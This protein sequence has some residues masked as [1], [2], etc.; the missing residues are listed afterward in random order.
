[1][2]WALVLQHSAFLVQHASFKDSFPDAKNKVRH[3]KGLISNAEPG[4]LKHQ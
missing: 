2:D 4:M 3:P 1:M